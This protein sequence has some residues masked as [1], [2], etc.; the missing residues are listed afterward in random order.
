MKTALVAATGKIG[1]H[2]AQ[3]AAEIAPGKKHGGY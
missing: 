3:S 2:I 1:H